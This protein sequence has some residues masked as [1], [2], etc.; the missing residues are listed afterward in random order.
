MVPDVDDRDMSDPTDVASDADDS[1]RRT[2][3]RGRPCPCLCIRRRREPCS[4]FVDVLREALVLVRGT[5]GIGGR[6]GRTGGMREALGGGKWRLEGVGGRALLPLVREEEEEDEDDG[7]VRSGT[8]RMCTIPA[9]LHVSSNV[10]GFEVADAVD[11]ARPATGVVVV[12]VCCQSYPVTR[13][14]TGAGAAD[15][16]TP[17]ALAMLFRNESRQP[18]IVP[19][20]RSW[21]SAGLTDERSRR[22]FH[23]LLFSG[24]AGS[25]SMPSRLGPIS[26]RGSWPAGGVWTQ[27]TSS[28]DPFRL[29]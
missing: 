29:K 15:V 1:E 9:P 18:S 6:C 25:M 10:H 7:M 4:P 21:E 19:C 5:W 23:R 24:V 11:G 8:P 16:N 22:S 12:V 14:R 17:K 2:H 27:G 20:G 3:E 13:V 28:P 26:G